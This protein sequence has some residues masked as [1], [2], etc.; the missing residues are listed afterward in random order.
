MRCTQ[1]SANIAVFDDKSNGQN[2][3][4]MSGGGHFQVACPRCTT[5]ATYEAS[6]IVQFQGE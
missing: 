1:C 3:P 5:E 6:A 2:P 4:S